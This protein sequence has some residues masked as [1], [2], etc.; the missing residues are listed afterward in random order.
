MTENPARARPLSRED[1][2]A[3][4]VAATVPL[5]VEYGTAVTTRQI[6]QAAGVAEGTLFRAFEDKD[7]ILR[8]T[9]CFVMDPEPMAEELRAVPATLPLADAVTRLVLILAARQELVMRVMGAAHHLLRAPHAH[10]ADRGGD[11]RDVRSRSMQVLLDVLAERLGD[12]RDEL[13]LAPGPASRVLFSIV[14]GNSMPIVG[15]EGRLEAHEIVDVVLRGIGAPALSPG[16][17]LSIP[18]SSE[19]SC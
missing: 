19:C 12:Y 18:H 14:M 17:L 16:A 2:R 15:D 8:A 13:R 5:L 6:A 3:A 4:I 9:V 10:G 1:R 11:H 7:E